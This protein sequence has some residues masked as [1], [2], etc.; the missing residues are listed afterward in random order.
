MTTLD[1]RAQ[2]LLQKD[3]EADHGSAVLVSQHNPELAEGNGEG[4][5]HEE[6]VVQEEEGDKEEGENDHGDE[7]FDEP[8]DMRLWKEYLKR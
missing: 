2:T 3:M 6:E 5:G 8:P 4:D 7:E 1:K